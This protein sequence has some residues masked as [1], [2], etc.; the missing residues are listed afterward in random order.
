MTGRVNRSGAGLICHAQ[1]H[2][3][4]SKFHCRSK[5][6][7]FGCSWCA[8]RRKFNV[9]SATSGRLRSALTLSCADALG[10]SSTS[11]QFLG[12]ERAIRRPRAACI[13]RSCSVLFA[14]DLKR[15]STSPRRNC[16]PVA[17][18]AAS[19]LGRSLKPVCRFRVAAAGPGEL[20]R[21]GRR[22]VVHPRLAPRGYRLLLL[23][24]E[25]TTAAAVARSERASDCA[26]QVIP[27]PRIEMLRGGSL[28]SSAIFC[29]E[30]RRQFIPVAGLFS[31]SR[32]V[33]LCG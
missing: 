30:N 10:S 16:A 7:S 27:G 33:S 18:R 20:H 19:S 21:A 24:A 31:L 12:S 26:C 29:R 25:T 1:R 32:P 4:A 13:A 5:N 11:F 28:P 22:R 15:T 9:A 14:P 17:G 3:D 8:R 2:V 23:L 6:W